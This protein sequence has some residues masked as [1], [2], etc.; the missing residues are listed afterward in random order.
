M[1][2]HDSH[3]SIQSFKCSSNLLSRIVSAVGN[4]VITSMSFEERKCKISKV[5]NFCFW[6]PNDNINTRKASRKV[7]RNPPSRT[8]H[9]KCKLTQ[10]S[11]N[12]CIKHPTI[13]SRKFKHPENQQSSALQL[14]LS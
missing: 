6:Y 12:S 10:L 2:N 8:A 9:L 5:G 13:P 4:R 14:L 7:K 11:L 1:G 3:F